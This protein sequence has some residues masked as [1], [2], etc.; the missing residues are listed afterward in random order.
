[1]TITY[2]IPE[3]TENQK[4]AIVIFKNEDGLEF[5]KTVSVPYNSDGSLNE[6]YWH[7]ILEGQLRGINN[8][9]SLGTIEFSEPV[10]EPETP[11]EAPTTDL[12]DSVDNPTE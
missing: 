3:L 1:M 8:K 10:L 5:R 2:Q 7:E 4:T 6:S 12:R 9:L 11:Y